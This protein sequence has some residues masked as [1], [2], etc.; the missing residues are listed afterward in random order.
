MEYAETKRVSGHNLWI[1]SALIDKSKGLDLYLR[2][3]F[4]KYGILS[5][6]NPEKEDYLLN[7]QD[8]GHHDF[9]VTEISIMFR[10]EQ[11]E[12]ELAKSIE[13]I[14]RLQTHEAGQ[15]NENEGEAEAQADVQQD[16]GSVLSMELDLEGGDDDLAIF[17]EDDKAAI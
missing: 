15:A 12:A 7:G 17:G 2:L 9:A 1:V 4:P 10:L 6:N 16:D 13:A 8:D 11:I 14:T 5:K 3:F